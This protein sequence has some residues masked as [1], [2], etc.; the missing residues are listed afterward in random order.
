MHTKREE[1]AGRYR[2]MS[3]YFVLF[4][5]CPRMVQLVPNYMF[6]EFGKVRSTVTQR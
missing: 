5:F 1:Y 2:V 4:E 3:F 6:L